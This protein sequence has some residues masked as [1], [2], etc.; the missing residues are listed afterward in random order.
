MEGFD[1]TIKLTND[2]KYFFI[3]REPDGIPVLTSEVYENKAEAKNGV[4]LLKE[5]ASIF[6]CYEIR[7]KQEGEYYFVF[8]TADGEVIGTSRTYPSN[9]EMFIHIDTLMISVPIA[10]VYD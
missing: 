10:D 2:S 8:K 5:N 9:R 4:K 1:I 6:E 7:T 3:L